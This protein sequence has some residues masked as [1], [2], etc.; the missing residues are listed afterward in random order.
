MAARVAERYLADRNP[1]ISWT[2]VA[3]LE[4][5]RL[6]R[7]V[8]KLKG[9]YLNLREVVDIMSSAPEQ[10]GNELLFA[11]DLLEKAGLE[12]QSY[13]NALRALLNLRG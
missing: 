13:L 11:V 3:Q 2:Q 8:V 1:V 10:S 4:R 6:A 7:K 12:I 9:A 5:E